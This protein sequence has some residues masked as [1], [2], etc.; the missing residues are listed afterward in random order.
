[1]DKKIICTAQNK[2]KQ[3]KTKSMQVSLKTKSENS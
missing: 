1:M 2:I 3:N